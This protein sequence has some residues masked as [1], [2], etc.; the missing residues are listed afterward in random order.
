[1]ISGIQN[2]VLEKVAWVSIPEKL[3]FYDYTGNNPTKDRRFRASLLNK[4]DVIIPSL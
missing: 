2:V 1:M 3:E 4:G